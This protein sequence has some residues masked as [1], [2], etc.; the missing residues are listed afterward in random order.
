M[1]ESPGA[2]VKVQILIQKLQGLVACEALLYFSSKQR[3]DSNAAGEKVSRGSKE[4]T[5]LNKWLVKFY[6]MDYQLCPWLIS[7]ICHML[8]FQ[9]TKLII[10]KTV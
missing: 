2:L 3:G 1:C 4:L 10:N 7:Y 6:L 9:L 8:Y 5:I